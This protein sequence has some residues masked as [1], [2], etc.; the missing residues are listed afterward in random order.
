MQSFRSLSL[1]VCSFGLASLLWTPQVRAEW[2][3]NLGYQ[4]PHGSRLGLNA[5]YW[6]SQ[7][8]FEAGLGWIDAQADDGSTSGSS[9]V[10][11]QLYGD[12][13]GKF[14]LTSGSI[15]PYLQLGIGTGTAASVGS[16]SGAGLSLQAPYV[17][18]G[19]MLGK[20]KF[21]GYGAY[22]YFWEA[23]ASE[24]QFGIGFGL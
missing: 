19:L 24:V 18:L 17:G 16:H 7:W 9:Q 6:G 23:K 5:L 8:N 4:N 14:R 21:Y 11:T 12:I 3:L 22:D 10:A 15:A 1:Y 20:S 13:N 2:S